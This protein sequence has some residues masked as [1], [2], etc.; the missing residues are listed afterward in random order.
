MPREKPLMNLPAKKTLTSVE[1]NSRATPTK[2]RVTPAKMTHFRPNL[3]ANQAAMREPKT[4]LG[5]ISD[6]ML[7]KG[8]KPTYDADGPPLKADCQL[9]SMT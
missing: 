4:E 5:D 6:M 1:T 7:H 9:A 8:P 2:V 3:S